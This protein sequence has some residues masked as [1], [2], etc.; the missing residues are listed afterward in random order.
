MSVQECEDAYLEL[1]KAIFGEPNRWKLDPRRASDFLRAKGKFDSDLLK[2]AI[3]RIIEGQVAKP[4]KEFLGQVTA[5]DIMLQNA[6]DDACK[7]YVNFSPV[8]LYFLDVDHSFK[9]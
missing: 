9:T 2:Q 4:G 5:A 6:Q 1:S 3:L 8:C 7:V